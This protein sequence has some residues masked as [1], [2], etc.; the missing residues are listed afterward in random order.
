VLANQVLF[1][2]ICNRISRNSKCQP[3]IGSRNNELLK[4]EETMS[5][6]R[7]DPFREFNA[8]PARLGFL[9]R[10]WDTPPATATWNPSVD[11]FENDNDVVIKAE[12]PGMNA[13][14]F[15]VRLE[16]NVLTIKG[17][18]HF[19]KETKEENYH[20]IERE[21]GNFTRSFALPTAVNGDKVTAEYK[22][23][24]LKIVLPKM[25]ETKT[26]PIRVAAA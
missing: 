13:K 3:N 16:N 11:I 2:P 22:D 14:D 18:R 23:G 17:E 26:K 19:E 4:G 12:V 8:L 20:R 1:Q 21:Y 25:E 6:I 9:G 7:W 15:D 10:D 24:V 5:L